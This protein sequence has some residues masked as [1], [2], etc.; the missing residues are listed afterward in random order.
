MTTVLERAAKIK[1]LICD[2]DGVL[3]DGRIYLTDF[4]E[5]KELKVLHIHDG[6]GLKLLLNA[7][8]EVAII[9]GRKSNLLPQRL[10]KILGIKYLYLGYEDK[11]PVLKELLTKLSLSPEQVAHIGDDLPD[12]PLIHSVGLGIAV[13]NAMPVVKQSAHWMTQANGGCGAVRE[14]CELILNAQGYLAEIHKSYQ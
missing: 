12:L 8:I 14:V 4:G 5:E 13:A 6:L 10:E 11:L 3:T 9:S 1:L 7:G 2:V